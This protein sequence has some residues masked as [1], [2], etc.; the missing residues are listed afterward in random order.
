MFHRRQLE[1]LVKRLHEPRRFIQV[2]LGPRQTGKTTLARQVGETADLA[3]H[4]ASADVPSLK[5]P[6]WIQQ[7][8]EVGRA[9]T[10]RRGRRRAATLVLDEIHKIPTWSEVCKALWDEDTAARIPLRVVF[11]GSSPWAMQR[12]L[13]ESLAGRFE[14][15][16]VPHWSF[17]E[18]KAAFGLGLDQY[19]CFGGYPGAAPLVKDPQR[20]AHYVQDSLV[21]TTLARDI[22][23]MTRVDKPALLRQVFDLACSYSGRILSYNKMLGQLQEAGNTT[24]LA[25]YLHLLREAGLACGIPKFAGQEVRQRASSPKL[26][27]F[28][29]ALVTARRPQPCAVLRSDPEDWG[30]LCESAVG[31]HLVNGRMETGT[32][33]YYWADRNREVDFI[34]QKGSVAVALEVKSSRQRDA[35]RGLEAFDAAFKPRRKLLVGPGG[36][37]FEEFLSSSPD[38]WL[39]P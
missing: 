15:I 26:Q 38:R 7:Q 31:A 11:L 30:R 35:L 9:M 23:L 22:L 27:V 4:Y 5:G 24:T 32:E 3:L 21:E 29:T 1:T 19:L 36:I 8:W 16:R 39:T 33:V 13:A 2:L 34:L 18:M 28:N 17:G 20:W 6:G 37:P 12:G 10:A 14:T 25:H